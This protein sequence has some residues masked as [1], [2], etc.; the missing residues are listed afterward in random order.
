MKIPLQEEYLY[1]LIEG[2]KKQLSGKVVQILAKAEPL[3]EPK[4]KSMKVIPLDDGHIFDINQVLPTQGAVEEGGIVI[5]P[6][7]NAIFILN[8]QEVIENLQVDIRPEM[9]EFAPFETNAPNDQIQAIRPDDAFIV[10][11]GKKQTRFKIKDVEDAVLKKV[12]ESLI[13]SFRTKIDASKGITKLELQMTLAKDLIEFSKLPIL[14][15]QRIAKEILGGT[16][17][18]NILEILGP[19]F[20][21]RPNERW[22][23][24][25]LMQK[26]EAPSIQTPKEKAELLNP[27]RLEPPLLIGTMEFKFDGVD[28][29]IPLDFSKPITIGRVSGD[30]L[31][32]EPSIS[33]QHAQIQVNEQGQFVITDL[34]STN[35]IFVDDVRIKSPTVITAD[36]KIRLGRVSISL[37]QIGVKNSPKLDTEYFLKAPDIIPASFKERV[38]NKLSELSD[39]VKE[40]PSQEQGTQLIRVPTMVEGK[41]ARSF[42]YKNGALVEVSRI[43]E[44]MAKVS[45]SVRNTQEVI[46]S[47]EVRFTKGLIERVVEYFKPPK[48]VIEVYL[49]KEMVDANG[50][51][52]QDTIALSPQ[53]KA[54]TSS[55]PQSGE[56]TLEKRILS[57]FLA[58]PLDANPEQMQETMQ[59]VL[60]EYAQ[61]SEQER[62]DI[63]E[64]ILRKMTDEGSPQTLALQEMME[65]IISLKNVETIGYDI[66]LPS[67]KLTDEVLTVV[68]GIS[69]CSEC[70]ITD[71]GYVLK[72]VIEEN[73][74]SPQ[75]K[76][77]SI[78]VAPNLY[79]SKETY[80]TLMLRAKEEWAIRAIKVAL[81]SIQEYPS[82]M[83]ALKD[84][85]EFLLT[86]AKEEE[87]VDEPAERFVLQ[88]TIAFL[89][90]Q[91]N[92]LG[93]ALIALESISPKDIS[94]TQNALLKEWK[95]Q[96]ANKIREAYDT[97]RIEA[98]KT[99]GTKALILA[100]AGV[101]DFRKA[102][103]ASHNIGAFLPLIPSQSDKKLSDIDFTQ[104]DYPHGRLAYILAEEDGFKR[105]ATTKENG[106]LKQFI[107]AIE[108]KYVHTDPR[109]LETILD[110]IKNPEDLSK[111]EQIVNEPAF[112]GKDEIPMGLSDEDVLKLFNDCPDCFEKKTKG[113]FEVKG[114]FG[115]SV[116][117]NKKTAI[118]SGYRHLLKHE[119]EFPRGLDFVLLAKPE[120]VM[121]IPS[122]GSTVKIF[123]YQRELLSVLVVKP[124][125]DVITLYSSYE[126]GIKKVEKNG[127]IVDKAIYGTLRQATYELFRNAETGELL[128]VFDEFQVR[129][130]PNGKELVVKAQEKSKESL[131]GFTLVEY[132]K[133]DNQQKE[134]E[135]QINLIGEGKEIEMDLSL[136]I[137][138]K[139]IGLV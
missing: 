107:Y 49:P 105:V 58:V 33:G 55:D 62:F 122:K 24:E 128:M 1:E 14:A 84:H 16:K 22:F 130:T 2:R 118:G 47:G 135:K 114:G 109:S 52:L 38:E 121:Q 10:T 98:T 138:G 27:E 50:K 28:K 131:K 36:S 100:E 51:P 43:P 57:T 75:R 95:D 108:N 20:N 34:K 129:F 86:R 96:I 120:K 7:N 123:R 60:E 56:Q 53:T 35:G 11:D 125:G 18:E 83:S 78:E 5:Q 26:E 124:T 139:E 136:V 31:I 93:K 132:E 45:L 82:K 74:G 25:T 89:A 81:H 37:S 59:G 94:S 127:K 101:E 104:F 23:Y 4:A 70:A 17:D 40:I 103:S 39:T 85:V 106:E 71:E 21:I 15:R 9:I 79:V 126:V 115:W 72:I 69:P 90:I 29:Q 65:N 54:Q 91:E 76:D 61:L 97:D 46:E 116:A 66:L 64:A 111:L 12:E 48:E 41:P 13:S 80:D 110:S 134:N 88:F 77:D 117:G 8:V 133:V 67:K 113:D 112:E 19:L 68:K 32:D 92:D 119:G 30:V 102:T 42:M 73:L 3:T 63:K 99:F 137:G 87:K 6:N 44:G